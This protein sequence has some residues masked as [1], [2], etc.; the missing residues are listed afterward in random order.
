MKTRLLGRLALP[1]LLLTGG[2]DE[3][4]LESEPTDSLS[5]A[6]FWRSQQDAVNAV[7]ALYPLLPG[8]GELQWDMMSDIGSSLSPASNTATVEKGEQNAAMGYFNG[9]WDGPY[10]AIRA[11]NAFLA[12]VDRIRQADPRFGDAT[13]RR[14]QAEA[15]FIRA[16]QYTR[17]VSLFGDVPLV[18]E[19]LEL[20]EARQVT[21]TPAARVW[22]FVGAE[23]TAIAPDLPLRYTGADMGRITRGAALAMKARAMLYAGRWADAA[24]AAKSVMELG[25]YSLHPSYPG[26]FTYA[27]E[28]NSE[29]ILDRQYAQGLSAHDFFFNFAPRTMNGEVGISPTRVLVDAYETVNGLSIQDDPAYNPR[30][31]YANRDPRLDHTLFLPAF[32]E[33]LPGERLYNN[34]RY[35]PRPGSGTADEV[36]RD[37]RRSKT[38]FNTQKYVAPE[39]LVD[40]RNSGLNFILI[41]YADVLLMYAEAKIELNQ[42]DPSVYDA[43]NRVRQRAD[44]KMPPITPGK[45]QAQLREIVRRERMVELAMEG[46]RFFD[47]RRWRTAE[48]VMQGPV[49]GFS[50]IRKGESQVSTL[51]YGGVVRSFNPARD[52]LWPLPAQEVV[53]NPK[54][55]QNPGY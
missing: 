19:P 7:N 17:L 27:A 23:L 41:R 26:L 3:G 30:N 53:L 54:L 25:V 43:I 32:S 36:E 24:A 22:D 1:L 18:T 9:Q 14:L 37:Y 12:N 50:Y 13:A 42:I 2:C 33:Q 47:L 44:V 45:S 10:R 20:D 49:P 38:G 11:A 4:L 55:T 6:T 29:V 51:S 8:V 40:R 46:L 34:R 31:P 39:D 48:A 15:R 52:Y 16:F 28:N 5:D 35:D 21:R